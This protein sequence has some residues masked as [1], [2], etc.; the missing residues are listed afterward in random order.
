[1]QV[2]QRLLT[3]PPS[4]HTAGCRCLEIAVSAAPGTEQQPLLLTL[5]GKDMS[6]PTTLESLTVLSPTTKGSCGCGCGCDDDPFVSVAV[7]L[8]SA[9]EA[10]LDMLD[11]EASRA[12]EHEA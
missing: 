12:R 9:T 4:D 3:L 2:L 1:V 8:P 10:A 6:T 7:V 5:G 11:V